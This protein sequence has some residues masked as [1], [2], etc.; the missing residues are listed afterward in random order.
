MDELEQ[1]AKGLR[2]I[3][4]QMRKNAGETDPLTSESWELFRAFFKIKDVEA[5]RSVIDLAKK[6]SSS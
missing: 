1:R 5:R 2:S 4:E 3:L 6:L